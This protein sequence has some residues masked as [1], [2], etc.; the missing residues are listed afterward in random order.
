MQQ[1]ENKGGIQIAGENFIRDMNTK[2]F[3]AAN[4]EKFHEVSCCKALSAPIYV[5]VFWQ[6][7]GFICW[8]FEWIVNAA[9]FT[10]LFCNRGILWSFVSKLSS[11]TSIKRFDLISND[12][13][14]SSKNRQLDNFSSI[15]LDSTVFIVLF[16]LVFSRTFP[17][18]SLHDGTI[19]KLQGRRTLMALTNHCTFSR[20]DAPLINVIHLKW[21]IFGSAMFPFLAHL[22]HSSPI[23]WEGELIA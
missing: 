7:S 13:F 2:I 21:F 8:I 16:C 1:V 22:L 3:C 15:L 20:K 17:S 5:Y 10:V 9:R 6:F 14:S 23:G 19:L 12:H 11:Q 4:M 18:N